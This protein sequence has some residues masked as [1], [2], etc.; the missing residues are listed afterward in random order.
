MHCA[1]KQD[2]LVHAGLPKTLNLDN[3]GRI[4]GGGGIKI[5]IQGVPKKVPS[6][7]IMPFV[8]NLR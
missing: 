1:K 6:I 7:E 3:L 5:N 8:V 4:G 2:N